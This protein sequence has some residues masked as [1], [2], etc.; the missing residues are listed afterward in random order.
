[1]VGRWWLLLGVCS[2]V[3]AQTAAMVRAAAH[4]FA[5]QAISPALTVEQR[6]EAAKL[7]QQAERDA[8]AG[9]YGEALRNYAHATAV[10]RH[11]RCAPAAE[12]AASI[13]LRV[14]HVLL[15]P[16]QPV[17][18]SLGRLY[19]VTPS[20][21]A[22]LTASIRLVSTATPAQPSNELIHAVALEPARIPYGPNP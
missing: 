19:P 12:L 17:T 5:A 18:L 11:A 10:M 20:E 9:R 1:M 2:S 3:F 14:E 4:D 16:S 13:E 15:E 6:N 7:R 21:E 22:K 8:Q